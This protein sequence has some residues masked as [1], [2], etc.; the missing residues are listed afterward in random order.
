MLRTSL[1]C[2]R[3]AAVLPACCALA[4][5]ACAGFATTVS[6]ASARPTAQATIHRGDPDG[7]MPPGLARALA[8][9]R[10]RTLTAGEMDGF[11]PGRRVFARNA[12]GWVVA[13]RVPR[14]RRAG[15]VRRLRRLGFVKALSER[16]ATRAG[17]Q[18]LSIVEQ[19][20]TTAAA[21]AELAY[22][23]SRAVSG[24]PMRFAPGGI[25]GARGFAYARGGANVAFT[26][27]P[28]YYLV[29]AAVAGPGNASLAKTRRIV[30]AGARHL[31][32]RVSR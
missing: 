5:A 19:F 25:P 31:Y 14:S 29:G 9:V 8:S 17:Q 32:R 24:T 22:E 4:V 10:G 2:R 7:A 13:T 30:I 12:R 21:R 27:G 18:G 11:T 16:L 26:K 1:P 15:D 6:P 3:L 20:H 23:T 28:Y